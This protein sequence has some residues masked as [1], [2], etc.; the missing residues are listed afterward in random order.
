MST[1]NKFCPD[2]S[3]LLYPVEKIPDNDTSSDVEDDDDEKIE[4]GLYLECD[5][6]SYHEKTNTY[7][8]VH[9]SKK[10]ENVQYAHPKRIIDDYVFEMTLP[11]TQTKPCSNFKCPTRGK[12]NPEIVLITSEKHPEIA[13]L[14]TVCKF[15]WG[16]M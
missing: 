2:C 11:R 16:K 12:K 4:G 3:R 15:T 14:C 10:V 8:T 7:S 6:C 1:I 9:F 13:Y 5:N